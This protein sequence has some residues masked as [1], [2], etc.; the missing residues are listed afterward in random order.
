[1]K[2]TTA[3]C[4][5]F[6]LTIGHCVLLAQQPSGSLAGSVTDNAGLPL[7]GAS[8]TV[9]GPGG[10]I[11]VSTNAQGHFRFQNLSFGDYEVK[12]E[13]GGFHPVVASTVPVGSRSLPRDF[14]LAPAM[15]SEEIIITAESPIIDA[16]DPSAV[17]ETLPVLSG[18]VL[19]SPRRPIFP[20]PRKPQDPPPS[21]QGGDVISEAYVRERAN[22]NPSLLVGVGTEGGKP[23]DK[24]VL[25]LPRKIE[26]RAGYLPPD[27]NVTENKEDVLMSGPPQPIAVFR[28]D[29]SVSYA[30]L[31]EGLTKNGLKVEAFSGANRVVKQ[32]VEVAQ[33]PRVTV[34]TSVENALTLPGKVAPGEPFLATLSGPVVRGK[35]FFSYNYFGNIS[36][37]VRAPLPSRSALVGPL[38]GPDFVS[39]YFGGTATAGPDLGGN[40]QVLREVFNRFGIAT[41]GPLAVED[42][43]FATAPSL[44][45][46]GERLLVRM[47]DP[48]GEMVVNG[49]ASSMDIAP[50]SIS[51]CSAK[52]YQATPRVFVGQVGCVCGCFAPERS[53]L[54]VDGVLSVESNVARLAAISSSTIMLRVLEG[55]PPGK[56]T[57]S[58]DPGPPHGKVEV[59]FIAMRLNGS[60]DKNKLLRGESTQM[61][62]EVL[63]TGEPVDI[64]VV[65]RTPTII[66]LEGG[67]SQV[68]RT[69]GGTANAGERTVRGLV[70]GDFRITYKADGP[71]CPCP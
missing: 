47:F 53:T 2:R 35:I 61:R 18:G 23:I 14:T 28:L 57:I 6:L 44:A 68:V 24:V 29:S 12:V 46:P 70:P 31:L 65:N 25:D 1:M 36:A 20:K 49:F 39:R 9:T 17:P 48:F 37:G 71:T 7:A 41:G 42:A 69:S 4:L 11:T 58:V 3:A 59:E 33:L 51:G 5:V 40:V 56:H 67:V 16:K 21:K 19:R 45:I 63:G 30:P 43:V 22:G 62:L 34:E 32:T 15:A 38:G 52:P 13:L 60:I 50:K 54:K 64:Q 8:V 26:F 55:A 27:W 10:S 66:D